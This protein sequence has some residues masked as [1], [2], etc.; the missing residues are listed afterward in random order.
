MYHASLIWPESLTTAAWTKTSHKVNAHHFGRS[1]KMNFQYPLILDGATGTELMKHGYNGNRQEE[2]I[3]EHKDVLIALKNEYIKAGSQAIYT[4]TFGANRAKLKLCGLEDKTAELNTQLV[5][6][7]KQPGI[8]TF[9][10]MGP[11]GLFSG[12]LGKTTI[13]ELYDIYREQASA[14]HSAGVDGFAIETMMTPEDTLAAVNACRDTADIPI[15]L[16]LTCDKRG[17][18]MTGTNITDVL[19]MVEPLGITAFGLNCSV[20]PDLML[21]QIKRIAKETDLPLIAKPNAGLPVNRGGKTVYDCTP[22]KFA[23]FAKDFVSCGV[24]FIGGCCGTTP[25]HIRLLANALKS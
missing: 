4:P 14:L 3:L 20:G 6:L 17:Y 21:E 1:L 13:E 8:L 22:E 16:S 15:L 9:G 18:L 10:D 25:E 7:I 24:R 5:N 12:R 23:S 19:K 11:T 2:W